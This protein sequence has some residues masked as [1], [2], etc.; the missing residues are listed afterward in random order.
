MT[1]TIIA[2]VVTCTGLVAPPSSA[3]AL[4][5]LTTSIR[6]YEA[7]PPVEPRPQVV[8]IERRVPAQEPARRLDGTRVDDPPAVYGLP[9]FWPSYVGS[10]R[11]RTDHRQ[12]APDGVSRPA[13]VVQPPAVQPAAKPKR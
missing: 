5:I 1:C 6:P 12:P 9:F 13:P 11:Y 4:R 2:A 7:P 8:V 3:E 10:P